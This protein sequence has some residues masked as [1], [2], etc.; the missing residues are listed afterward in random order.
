LAWLI[1]TATTRCDYGS[2]PS[3]TA[4]VRV[5]TGWS[6][7][8]Q[9]LSTTFKSIQGDSRTFNDLQKTCTVQLS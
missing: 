4:T 5:H 2:V 8:M 6:E 9:A 7:N 1:S 3:D